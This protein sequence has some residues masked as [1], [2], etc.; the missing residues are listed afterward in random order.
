MKFNR[1]A[2][3]DCIRIE[4]FISVFRCKLQDIPSKECFCDGEAHDFWEFLHLVSGELNILVDGNLFCLKPG[5]LILYAPYSFHTISTASDA[6]VSVCAFSAK[7]TILPQ[8]AN[9]VIPLFEAHIISLSGIINLGE[10]MFSLPKNT[11]TERGM[12]IRERI[13]DFSMQKLAN[14]TELFIIDLFE[15]KLSGKLPEHTTNKSN[16][17]KEFSALTS[18][19]QNNMHRNLSTEEI[20][21][22][23]SMS[24]SHLGKLCKEMCG[25]G[26]IDY[27]IS[28][29]IGLAKRL[30][31]ESVLNLTQISEKL[32]FSS[33]HYFSR[34]FKAKTGISPSNFKKHI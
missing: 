8:F 27:F 3:S 20:C 14:L 17:N 4:E 7:S 13:S 31:T 33:V 30:I 21:T 12:P 19:L 5:D 22:G 15:E 24:S 18:F 1:T 25:C 26:P 11:L 10:S 9:T 28:L 6:V 16:I 32:G 29:K 2:V 34:L 23:L